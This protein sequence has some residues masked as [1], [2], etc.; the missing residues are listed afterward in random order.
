MDASAIMTR[1]V[2]S[3]V[4]ESPVHEVAKTM[5]ENRISAVP[6]VDRGAVIGI[7]SEGDLLRRAEIG[8]EH[9][10]SRWLELAF[11][12]STLAAEY[13]KEHSRRA[14][15]VMTRDVITVGP[16][17]SAAEIA[18]ILESRHIKRVPVVA[19]GAL[20][21]IVSR[22]NL[23]QALASIGSHPSSAGTVQDRDIQAALYRE[24]RA[25]RWAF[26]PS[27]RNVVVRNGEV[28]LWG[29]IGSQEAR[30]ALVVMAEN[31]PGVRR[32]EDNMAYP[33]IPFGC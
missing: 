27:D 25:Q 17:T 22:A 9:R 4:P 20:V 21:G 28:S 16:S 23:I 19:E 33:P 2:V 26:A 31:I 11:S 15:D 1:T 3:V 5:L 14:S 29:Y 13:A 7:I 32:V 24:M 12:N 8:T 18:R 6:V 10:R 30:R